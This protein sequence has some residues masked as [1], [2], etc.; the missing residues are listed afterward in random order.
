MES[1]T[2]ECQGPPPKKAKTAPQDEPFWYRDWYGVKIM[3]REE[4]L[5]PKEEMITI[6]RKEYDDLRVELELLKLRLKKKNQ[7]LLKVAQG[8]VLESMKAE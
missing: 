2:F 4:I 8:L 7:T 6:T 3:E 1:Y 5:P